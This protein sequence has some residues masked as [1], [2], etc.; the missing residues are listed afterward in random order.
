LK[1]CRVFISISSQACGGGTTL[2]EFRGRGFYTSLLAIRLQAAKSHGIR[3][4][5]IDASPMSRAVVEKYGF[6]FIEYTQPHKWQ[7]K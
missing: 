3:Y 2:E 1:T 5:A 6:Q 7:I 4:L